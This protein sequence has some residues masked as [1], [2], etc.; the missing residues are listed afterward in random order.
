MLGVACLFEAGRFGYVFRGEFYIIL[1]NSFEASFGNS[2]D[3]SFSRR[4][5]GVAVLDEVSGGI[6]E[7][8]AVI[9]FTDFFD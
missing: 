2:I 7:L 4:D 3:V 5:N 8:C 1:L 9:P 6:V